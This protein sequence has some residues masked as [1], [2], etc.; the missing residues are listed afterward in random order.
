MVKIGCC[1]FPVAKKAYYMALSVVEIQKTFYKLPSPGLAARWREEAPPDF[2]FTLKA[3][4]GITHPATSPTYRKAGL[5]IPEARKGSY[6]HFR[7]TEEVRRAWEDTLQ[8]AEALGAT[9]AVFQCPPDFKEN[10]ENRKNL[11]QFFEGINRGKLALAI[12]F[13]ASWE[14]ESIREICEQHNLVHCVDPFKENSQSG[15]FRYY[16]L[17]GSPPGEKM[18]RYRYQQQDFQ[19]LKDRIRGDLQHISTVYCLFNNVYMWDDARA[20]LKYWRSG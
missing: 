11:H 2:E 7:P 12:E 20:F 9:V 4:Q 14:Q 13:R 1:G 10:E 19:F 16:R 17:H 3:W 15:K 5:H 6:G 18:Y 8:F